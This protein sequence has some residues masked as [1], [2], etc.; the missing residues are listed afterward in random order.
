MRV[1][2]H[3]F[4]QSKPILYKDVLNAYTK[5]GMYCLMFKDRVEKHG[6]STIFRVTEYN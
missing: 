2:V 3:L 5:D 1:K 6:I 4:S